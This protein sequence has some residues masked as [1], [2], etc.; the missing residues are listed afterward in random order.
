M[1][2]HRVSTYNCLS[3]SS[4]HFDF[5]N[6][7]V[8]LLPPPCDEFTTSD[9]LR[10]ATR[11]RPPGTIV[12][13]SPHRMYG[14]RSTWRAC[15][16]VFDE[17]GRPRQRQRGLRDVVSRV[18]F[19]PVP[20][21]LALGRGALRADQHPVA[22]GFADRLHH[23]LVEVIEHVRAILVAVQQPG[24]DV[25][26]GSAPGHV[27]P[28]DCRHVGVERLVV[29]HARPTAFVTATLPARNALKMPATPSCESARNASG[30]RKSSSTRR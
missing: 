22:P 29:R 11:V 27:K 8:S 15:D 20:E 23:D 5:S 9:P 28:D 30:S 14:R 6:T 26:R 16:P 18:G 7:Q 17:A 10:S 13:R 4:S 24:V 19:D 2:S 25:R 12:T 21:V 3:L 1:R